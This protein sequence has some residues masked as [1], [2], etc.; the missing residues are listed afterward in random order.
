MVRY[1]PAE[2]ERAGRAV[3][4]RIRELRTTPVEVARAARVDPR[5]V[6]AL[7][8]G[9]RWPTAATREN[10]AVALGWR[11]GDIVRHAHGDPQLQS[12]TIRELLDELCRRVD[13]WEEAISGS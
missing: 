5:T 8:H 11:P 10:I 13:A 3:A 6:R 12:F 1:T 7:L 9:T 4:A 2:R